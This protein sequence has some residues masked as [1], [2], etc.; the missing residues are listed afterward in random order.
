MAKES[1]VWAGLLED[2]DEISRLID[3]GEGKEAYHLIK[4][5]H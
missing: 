2:W 3:N 5:L 4:R 1:D